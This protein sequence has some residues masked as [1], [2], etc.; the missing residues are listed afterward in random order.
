MF[1]L[2]HRGRFS[3]SDYWGHKWKSVLITVAC[4]GVGAWLSKGANVTR[5]GMNVASET[6][7]TVGVKVAAKKAAQS[8][9]MAILKKMLYEIG[10]TALNYGKSVLIQELSAL[11]VRHIVRNFRDNILS[12]IQSSSSYTDGMR[13]L[14]QSLTELH[15]L[16]SP[17]E[18]RSILQEHIVDAEQEMN[19]SINNKIVS[20]TGSLAGP[21]ASQVIESSQVVQYSGLTVEKG[22]LKNKQAEFYAEIA[23][24]I[25]SAMS[26][27]KH[28]NSLF[29]LVML[30]GELVTRISNKIRMVIG[31]LSNTENAY[32]NN[33]EQRSTEEN[34]QSK[35]FFTHF[36]S[37]QR[38]LDF[39][40]SPKM[41]KILK[42]LKQ[43]KKILLKFPLF[44]IK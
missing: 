24:L 42:F 12:M 28:V 36:V 40:F 1:V 3:M 11:F 10:K 20:F 23:S 43:L 5:V 21:L 25:S 19:E 37:I 27:L 7:V 22:Q 30:V 26:Y 4:V 29:E 39:R 41:R 6:M 2:Q 16:K 35:P 44:R 13:D 15:R 33:R 18:T 17:S 32:A 9:T 34:N 31:Q 8:A 38:W 14:Q